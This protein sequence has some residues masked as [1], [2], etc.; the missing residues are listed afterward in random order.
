[1][2]RKGILVAAVTLFLALFPARAQEK[3]STSTAAEG[4]AAA[5]RIQVVLTEYDGEKKVSSLPYSVPVALQPG[6]KRAVG[7]VR[8][9]IR[10]P[11]ATSTKTGE[12]GIQ[13]MDV[14]TN[15]DVRMRGADAERYP[16]EL[17]IERSWL[18]VRDQS[19]DGKTEGRSWVPGDPAPSST[20]LNHQFRVMVEFLLRDGRSAETTIATDPITGHVYKVDAQLTVLK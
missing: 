12:S 19:R 8:V 7:S 3:P 15:L 18:Y 5:F 13:Y 10:V 4:T 17:T 14:G 2:N 6:E 16:V 11:V 9:G 1:M 20:P